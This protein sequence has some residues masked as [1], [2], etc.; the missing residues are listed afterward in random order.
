VVVDALVPLLAAADQSVRLRAVDVLV[1]VGVEARVLV[2]ALAPLLAAADPDMR[3]GA[4]DVLARVGGVEA[5][6]LVDALAPLLAAADPNARAGAAAT[7][8]RIPTSVEI[9]RSDLQALLAVKRPD[10]RL[11]V[12]NA[13][14]RH[15][16]VIPALEVVVP[17]LTDWSWA[18][19]AACKKLMAGQSLSPA[20]GETLAE[21][22][23]RKPQDT[24]IQRAARREVFDWL[25]SCQTQP[26]QAP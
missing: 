8:A 3:L 9:S 20:D 11:E 16:D 4:V 13:L 5:R 6:V 7:L 21:V 18:A 26:D 14:L 23:R 24:T 25:W 12:A 2:D 10:S 22:V 15:R 17:T 1:R 19:L